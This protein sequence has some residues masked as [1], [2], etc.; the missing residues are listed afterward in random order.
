MN[1]ISEMKGFDFSQSC[2]LNE[3]KGKGLGQTGKLVK[4]TTVD[5]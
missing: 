4:R 3:K 1:Q 5:E 2:I